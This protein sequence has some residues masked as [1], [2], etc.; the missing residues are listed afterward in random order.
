MRYST[1][2]YLLLFLFFHNSYT[3][4]AASDHYYLSVGETKVIWLPSDFSEEGVWSNKDPGAIDIIA[5]WN[6]P[7]TIKVIDYVDHRCLL[8]YKESYGKLRTYSVFIDIRKTTVSSITLNKSS[9]TLTEGET[10][11]NYTS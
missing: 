4:K 8:E 11:G 2:L 6:N 10:R 1:T 3:A 5:G 9:L 7:I